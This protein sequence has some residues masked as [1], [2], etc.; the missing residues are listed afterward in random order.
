MDIV[1][2]IA[3]QRSNNKMAGKFKRKNTNVTFTWWKL[4]FKYYLEKK[5][6]LV[7]S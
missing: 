4:M 2:V 1:L 7:S 3:C 5:K 6:P